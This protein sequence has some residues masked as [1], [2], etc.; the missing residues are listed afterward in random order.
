MQNLFNN[1]ETGCFPTTCSESFGRIVHGFNF[2][3]WHFFFNKVYTQ[4]GTLLNDK[5]N[6]S[7]MCENVLI[8]PAI[9]HTDNFVSVRK[10]S[11]KNVNLLPK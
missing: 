6:Q 2:S 9:D 8:K 11:S 4:A 1:I 7:S 3:L 10:N 5:C